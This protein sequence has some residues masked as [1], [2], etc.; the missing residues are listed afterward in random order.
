MP[1]TTPENR[2]EQ[3][4]A[5]PLDR[6]MFE[7][8]GFDRR[9]IRRELA[10]VQ[11]ISLEDKYVQQDEQTFVDPRTIDM[12]VGPT[13]MGDV[14]GQGI[15]MMRIEGERWPTFRWTQGFE[16]LEEDADNVAD[17]RNAVL[18]LFD[19]FADVAF[20]TGI[21]PDGNYV[22]GCF[23]W[24]RDSIPESRTFD[25]DEYTD[26]TE[27]E[28]RPENVIKKMAL[29]EVDG[30]LMDLENASWDMMV[31]SQ[32]ALTQFNAVRDNDGTGV[33]GDTYWDAISSDETGMGQVG[34]W[35]LLPPYTAPAKVPYLEDEDGETTEGGDLM[36]KFKVQLVDDSTEV[37][38]SGADDNGVIGTDEVFLLPRMDN[39]MEE[40]WRLHEMSEPNL[41]GPLQQR[42]GKEAYDYAWRYTHNF[43][44][45]RRHPNATDAVHIKNVS[46]L[47]N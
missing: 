7:R 46:A 37:K 9:G 44:P 40:F 24:L 42:G 36:D 35:N 16:V 4:V 12:P 6:Q 25:L 33:I 30:R 47:F 13:A 39:V 5:E 20:L 23:D 43:N 19:F 41:F 8:E 22:D 27:L 26:D 32:D 21:G 45:R 14:E 29:S 38:E 2:R 18:E 3:S 11:A 28:N 17:Q 34:D 15:D 1:V 31:G 10:G